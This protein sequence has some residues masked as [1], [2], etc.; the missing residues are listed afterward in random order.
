MSKLEKKRRGRRQP[1]PRS[2]PNSAT[3]SQADAG[4]RAVGMKVTAGTPRERGYREESRKIKRGRRRDRGERQEWES[5]G[6]CG[7]EASP[8]QRNEMRGLEEE[9]ER[10]R[11]GP[12]DSALTHWQGFISLRGLAVL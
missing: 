3:Q 11:W 7:R 4:K 2:C 6:G 10:E 5:E 8:S 1:F 9:R 12:L